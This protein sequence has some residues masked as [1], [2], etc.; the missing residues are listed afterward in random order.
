MLLLLLLVSG[1]TSAPSA[2]SLRVL[3]GN[4]LAPAF[5]QLLILVGRAAAQ[6]APAAGTVNV[7]RLRER[8]VVR[9]AAL[10]LRLESFV[11]AADAE[12][13]VRVVRTETSADRTALGDGG[14]QRLPRSQL[15]GSTARPLG[16][17]SKWRCGLRSG[18]ETPTVPI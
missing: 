17:I 9:A 4:A 1:R 6:D 2:V 5:M 16:R 18:S 15:S 7:S 12:L 3:C 14:H 13:V 8:V 11:S 10:A